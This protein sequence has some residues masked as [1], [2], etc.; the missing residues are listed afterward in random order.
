MGDEG[1]FSLVAI[2][3]LHVVVSPTNIEF[4]EDF[5]I[6]QFVNEIGDEGKGVG[7]TDGMFVDVSIVLARA[8]SSVLLFNEEKGGCLWRVGWANLP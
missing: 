8:K 1:C 7:V 2:L 6:L 3:D 5:G 4:G